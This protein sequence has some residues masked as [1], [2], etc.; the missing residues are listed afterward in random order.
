MSKELIIQLLVL[1]IVV[2]NVIPFLLFGIDKIKAV[3]MG[4]RISEKMLLRFSLLGPFG[5]FIAMKV[6]RHKIKKPR[7]YVGIP[8][9][10]IV[11]G[12]IIIVCVLIFWK[13]V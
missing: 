10:A 12:I 6:F 5:S 2:L 1:L 11:Q 8:F 9:F 13:L 4:W 7:F 3:N